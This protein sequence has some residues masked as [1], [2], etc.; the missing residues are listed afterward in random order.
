MK[1]KLM[2]YILCGCT[3][4]L[5][6]MDEFYKNLPKQVRVT[7]KN[8]MCPTKIPAGLPV[9]MKSARICS[10]EYERFDM[11]EPKLWVHDVYSNQDIEIFS[12]EALE[13]DVPI[14]HELTY[15]PKLEARVIVRKMPKV[16]VRIIG[17]KIGTGKSVAAVIEEEVD[18]E[19][20]VNIY[21]MQAPPTSC[22]M[23]SFDIWVEKSPFEDNGFSKEYALVPFLCISSDEEDDEKHYSDDTYNLSSSSSEG[24]WYGDSWETD[25]DLDDSSEES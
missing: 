25:S 12:G 16:I 17:N 13:I 20:T 11:N 1:L 22:Q 2:I 23:D 19:M 9:K 4:S 18:H 5:V 14:T 15:D 21:G 8:S 6:G 10:N 24:E 3:L 7:I